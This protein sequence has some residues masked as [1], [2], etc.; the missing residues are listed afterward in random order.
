MYNP[1]AFPHSFLISIFSPPGSTN[2][3][4]Y[5]TSSTSAIS[6]ISSKDT[7]LNI[8]A[9]RNRESGN[10]EIGVPVLGNRLICA[11]LKFHFYGKIYQGLAASAVRSSCLYKYSCRNYD[12]VCTKAN[13]KSDFHAPD[14]W[15]ISLRII[16][17][18]T[19]TPVT[20]IRLTTV[21]ITL[22]ISVFISYLIVLVS[23]TIR[24]LN[25]YAPFFT[26]Q[27]P[28]LSRTPG[29]NKLRQKFQAVSV[30]LPFAAVPV[31]CE[32]PAS[33]LIW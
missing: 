15:W 8:L 31:L 25:K 18:P 12:S 9:A 30:P 26:L 6:I 29:T 22:T 27:L 11:W 16:H 23:P 33:R 32:M 10:L 24:Y 5:L 14:R 7:V 17:I 2:A 20:N 13:L 4:S 19:A 1:Y 3:C 21:T 28:Q